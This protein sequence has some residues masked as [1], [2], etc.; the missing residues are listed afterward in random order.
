MAPVLCDAAAEEWAISKQC[1]T[2]LYL[3][4]TYDSKDIFIVIQLSQQTHQC[5]MVLHAFDFSHLIF[6]QSE[7]FQI[8]LLSGW[9]YSE[10][11]AK[12]WKNKVIFF[13]FGRMCFELNQSF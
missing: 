8:I 1:I 13:Y 3:I 6:L 4:I 9:N 7:V 5:G 10:L 11:H 2:V 12:N